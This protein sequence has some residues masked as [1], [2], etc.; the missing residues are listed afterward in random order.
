MLIINKHIASPILHNLT[1]GQR[2]YFVL[3]VFDVHFNRNSERTVSLEVYRPDHKRVH[4]RKH[5]PDGESDDP[6]YEENTPSIVQPAYENIAKVTGK[7]WRSESSEEKRDASSC[8]D[9]RHESSCYHKLQET[10]STTSTTSIVGNHLPRQKGVSSITKDTVCTQ[11]VTS[12]SSISNDNHHGYVSEQDMTR[13]DG[14]TLYRHRK[15]RQSH[16]SHH[17]NHRQQDMSHHGNHRQP[18][19]SYHGHHRQSYMSH[20]GNNRK[21]DMSHHGNHRQP[22]TSRNDPRKSQ[23]S[24]FYTSYQHSFLQHVYMTTTINDDTTLSPDC[25][26]VSE[27]GTISRHCGAYSDHSDS[28]SLTSSPWGG[29][30]FSDLSLSSE[31]HSCCSTQQAALQSLLE[32]EQDFVDVMHRGIQMFSRPLRHHILTSQQHSNIFQNIEKVTINMSYKVLCLNDR[33]IICMIVYATINW[34]RHQL[35]LDYSNFIIF[36]YKELQ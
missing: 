2:L 36:S 27:E 9:R 7:R 19:V 32:C 6:C 13:S 35:Y 8:K 24:E 29:A 33:N 16:V 30:T 3:I 22:D 34:L 25:S 14:H 26:L 12:F 11:T 21:P 5:S 23:T 31:E 18:D 28:D 10:G 4:D 15:H 20:H 1:I 17:G